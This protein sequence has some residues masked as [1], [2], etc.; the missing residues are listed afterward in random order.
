MIRVNTIYNYK[1][2]ELVCEAVYLYTLIWDFKSLVTLAIRFF[3]NNS[4]SCTVFSKDTKLLNYKAIITCII[5][6]YHK[7]VEKS[8]MYHYDFPTN[9]SNSNSMYIEF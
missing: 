4:N 7:L 8:E 3:H 1:L 9:I 2:E 6:R 5:M